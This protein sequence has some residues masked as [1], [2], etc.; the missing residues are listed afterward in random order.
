MIKDKIQ[1]EMIL[2]GLSQANLI[3]SVNCLSKDKT[4]TQAQLSNF[5]AS[6]KLL[7]TYHIESI[8]EVLGIVL[9]RIL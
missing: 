2:Q 6:K 4:L 1:E 9:I 5:L 3:R 7:S 8:F